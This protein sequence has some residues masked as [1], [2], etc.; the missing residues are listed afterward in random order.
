MYIHICASFESS[1]ITH[2]QQSQFP[3]DPRCASSIPPPHD[4]NIV[5]LS[6]R[7]ISILKPLA[8]L[9]RLKDQGIRTTHRRGYRNTNTQGSFLESATLSW[10][11]R[12]FLRS[13]STTALVLTLDD[14][15]ALASPQAASQPASQIGSRPTYDTKPR[16]APKGAPSPVT[17]TPLGVSFLDVARQ[18]GL[19]TKTIYG[20]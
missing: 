10:N 8:C 12:S 20:G 11:R 1:S 13:L 6:L 17:G 18:A 5:C 7:D 15:L 4:K 16:P 19:N 9:K 3:I 2:K 14:I